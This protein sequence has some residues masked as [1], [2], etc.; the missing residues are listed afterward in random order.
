MFDDTKSTARP[1]LWYDTNPDA[2]RRRP[3]LALVIRADG[4]NP[5]TKP[6]QRSTDQPPAGMPLSSPPPPK[7][8]FTQLTRPSMIFDPNPISTFAG[9]LFPTP[10]SSP[11]TVR[12]IVP[13]GSVM[14][15]PTHSAPDLIAENT[16][17]RPP[18]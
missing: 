18:W 4:S 9:Q 8:T 13:T 11:C 17:P 12:L 7:I 5:V 6:D 2:V 1:R 15:P 3:R 16:S 10:S 14:R